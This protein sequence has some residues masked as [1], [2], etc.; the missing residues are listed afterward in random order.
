[1]GGRLAENGNARNSKYPACAERRTVMGNRPPRILL[2]AL[3]VAAFA[4][5]AGADERAT[6]DKG[7]WPDLDARVAIALPAYA[8]AAFAASPGRDRD[9]DGIPDPLDVLRGAKKALLNAASYDTSFYPIP[10]PGGDVPRE[11]EACSDVVVRALRNAGLDLQKAI[12][13]DVR[14][15]PTAYPGVPEQKTSIDHRRVRNQVVYFSRYLQ[16]LDTGVD[17]LHPEAWLPGDI[18]LFDTLS[19]PGPDHIGIVS[20]SIGPSGLPLVINNWTYGSTTAEMDL[21]AFVPVTDHF[22][23]P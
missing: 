6:R 13:E 19:K 22:R 3:A 18:A 12:A 7:I 15:R 8:K 10:Y 23:M 1:M 5:S 14:R 20:D 17:A 2:L 21:L 11:V 9:R 4:V 16:R